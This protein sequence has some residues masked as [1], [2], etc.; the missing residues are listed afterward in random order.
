MCVCMYVCM[1]GVY[2]YAAAPLFMHVSRTPSIHSNRQLNMTISMGGEGTR[3]QTHTTQ[4]TA[5]Q[6]QLI[7]S[8][9]K[10]DH[11]MEDV[12]VWPLIAK[13]YMYSTHIASII[14]IPPA[15]PPPPPPSHYFHSHHHTP[16][17]PA[18]LCVYKHLA[19]FLRS[20]FTLMKT[21]DR[22]ETSV[23]FL[24]TTSVQ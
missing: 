21:Q 3:S 23:Y 5:F 11:P 18:V 2:I 17:I 19:S 6:L 1:Y 9:S 7:G 12:S 15:P 4:T 16:L 22:V 24:T 8:H 14:S 10:C 13:V 20:S